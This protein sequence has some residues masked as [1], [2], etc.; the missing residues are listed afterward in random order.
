[1][2]QVI[3][4]ISVLLAGGVAS[5]QQILSLEEFLRLVRT[6][7]PVAKQAALDVEI[8]KTEVTTARGSFDPMFE[9]KISRKEFDGL[10]YYDHQVSEI[11]IPT[12]YGVDI[13]T[14]IESLRGSRTSTPDTKGNS[15]Y[16]GFSV[17]IAKGLVIDAR[18][19]TLQQAKIFK[20]LSV[21]EQR[22][23]LNDLLYEASKEYWNW[24]Q[25]SWSIDGD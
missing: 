17:P 13:I 8:A 9:N 15:S 21:Q 6:Y 2:K 7:H 14:G 24:W 11:K 23:V 16:L 5:A 19:A 4:I 20:D 18:R 3:I 22:T 10:L 25:R 1:M 12:W